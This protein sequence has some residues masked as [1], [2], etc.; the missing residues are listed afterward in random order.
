MDRDFILDVILD[1]F[2]GRLFQ[3]L[4]LETALLEYKRSTRNALVG[5]GLRNCSF[6]VQA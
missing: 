2:E 6:G 3:W 1:G 4:G 5:V